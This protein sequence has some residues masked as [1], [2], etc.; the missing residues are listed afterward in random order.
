[1]IDRF[2]LDT[3]SDFRQTPGMMLKRICAIGAIVCFGLGLIGTTSGETVPDYTPS[4]AAK[5]AGEK[6]TVTGKVED[7]H[8]AQGGSIFLNMG[9]RH[10]NEEFTAFIP[11]KYADKFSEAEKYDGATVSISGKI[12]MHEGKPEIIVTAPSQITQKE[13]K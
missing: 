4:E 11:S 9:G 1:M 13:K 7:V 6:A 2:A 3:G 10:P 5:H 8:R 12:E